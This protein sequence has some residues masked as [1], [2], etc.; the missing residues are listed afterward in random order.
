[1]PDGYREALEN[2]R[3]EGRWEAKPVPCHSTLPSQGTVMW[4]KP[5]WTP[6]AH[7][8]CLSKYKVIPDR[9]GKVQNK[10]SHFFQ[11]LSTISKQICLH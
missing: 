9:V 7:S 10:L 4:A 1:M 11:K 2:K 6:E 8:N 5:T 3:Q